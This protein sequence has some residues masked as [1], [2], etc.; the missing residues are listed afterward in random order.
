[1]PQPDNKTTKTEAVKPGFDMPAGV[2][3]EL[4]TNDGQSFAD[5][6]F[7]VPEERKEAEKSEA[8]EKA[9]SYPALQSIEAWFKEQI[10]LCDSIDNIQTRVAEINGVKVESKISIE[11]QVYAYQLLKQLLTDKHSQYQEFAKEIE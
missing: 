2:G 7:D 11:A 1:M 5:E 9:A 10:A 3:D 8:A 4:Y 6:Y